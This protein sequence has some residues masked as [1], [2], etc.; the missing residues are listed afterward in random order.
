MSD[1]IC[2][3]GQRSWTPTDLDR[4]VCPPILTP[5]HVVV[6]M[7]GGRLPRVLRSAAAHW[8]PPASGRLRTSGR[9]SG[10][11]VCDPLRH[12]K[13]VNQRHPRQ[14]G[15]VR[16]FC[17]RRFI[18][19]MSRIIP[20]QTNAISPVGYSRRKLAPFL[21][22]PNPM[23]Q[24]VRLLQIKAKFYRSYV[25]RLSVH[26]A[27][28]LQILSHSVVFC[29]QKNSLDCGRKAPWCYR[30]GLLGPNDNEVEYTGD[31]PIEMQQPVRALSR[32]VCKSVSLK[33][34]GYASFAASTESSDRIIVLALILQRFKSARAADVE[35]HSLFQ[36]SI[37]RAGQG[38]YGHV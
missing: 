18:G 35:R 28:R 23:L 30:F 19:L 15:K 1:P 14:I 33:N 9:C 24:I 16:N 4:I 25:Q 2:G 3:S 10:T 26:D 17:S 20:K 5:T 6:Q 22:K 34:Q 12:L 37:V 7:P 21:Q 27:G 11:H 36:A 8:Q 29:L 38:N 13:Q 31:L 32:S